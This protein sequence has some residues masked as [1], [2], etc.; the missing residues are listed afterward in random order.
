MKQMKTKRWQLHGLVSP[1]HPFIREAGAL[2]LQGELIAFPTETV[3]GL[4]AIADSGEAVQ[5]IFNVKGRPADNPLI[6]HLA[7]IETVATVAEDI[8]EEAW[9]L[10]ETFAPGPLTIILKGKSVLSPL[11]TA[12]LPSVAVRIP[13]HPVAR[14]LIASVKKP[15]AAP[16]ANRSGRP[17]PTRAEH[18]LQDLDGRIAGILDAGPTGYGVESTVLDMTVFPYTILRPGAVTLS[19]LQGALGEGRVRLHRSFDFAPTVQEPERDEAKDTED[20]VPRAPGMKYRHYAPDVPLTLWLFNGKTLDSG[21]YDVRTYLMRL[22][23]AFQT[24]VAEGVRISFLA[25]EED[26]PILKAALGDTFKTLH[27][28]NVGRRSH[29]EEVARSLYDVLRSLDPEVTD[30]A[31]ML[32]LREE[33]LGLAIMNRLR[34]AASEVIA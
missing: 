30:R 32:G 23:A 33:G 31:M 16:S 21:S 12:G 17:S 10:L 14:S 19:D 7:E 20:T 25:Y 22:K 3:Y 29:P 24:M 6:V 1:D 15:V 18:V 28:L 8:P 27:V 13:A 34:K 2:L 5:K 4:G 11:V 9:V 26:L